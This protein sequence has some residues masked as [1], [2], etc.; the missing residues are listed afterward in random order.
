MKWRPFPWRNCGTATRSL[1]QSLVPRWLGE[2]SNGIADQRRRRTVDAAAVEL[3][4][5]IGNDGP[6]DAVLRQHI[7]GLVGGPGRQE[8]FSRGNRQGIDDLSVV[9]G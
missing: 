9:G 3:Q 1:G 2:P 6:A 4:L 7:E 5:A 8:K